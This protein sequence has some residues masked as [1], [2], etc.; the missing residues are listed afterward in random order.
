MTLD[1]PHIDHYDEQ[2]YQDFLAQY[3]S[4]L[5]LVFEEKRA[6]FSGAVPLHNRFF[7][8]G[9][10]PLVGLVN[11]SGMVRLVYQEK[12]FEITEGDFV[13]FDDNAIHAWDFKDADVL[14]FYYRQRAVDLENPICSG[15]YCIDTLFPEQKGGR[16]EAPTY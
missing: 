10:K 16:A 3:F 15:D 2:K 5:P 1:L 9:D 14:I 11:C 12:T 7:S 4:N 6:S 8:N 13:F